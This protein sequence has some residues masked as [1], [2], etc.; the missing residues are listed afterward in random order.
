MAVSDKTS[1]GMAPP[2]R[3]RYLDGVVEYLWDAKNLRGLICLVERWA[4]V[5]P[6]S[7]TG[8]LYQIR[9]FLALRLMDRAWLQLKRLLEQDPDD[10]EALSMATEMFLDRGWPSRARKLLTDA[11]QRM[12]GA[13]ELPRLLELTEGPSRTPPTNAREIELSGAP[14]ELLELAERFLSTGSF[15]RARALLERARQADPTNARIKDLLW[16][17]DGDFDAGDISPEELASQLAPTFQDHGGFVS[18]EPP[19]AEEVT[20]TRIPVDDED[21]AEAEFPALFRRVGL[22]L[23]VMDDETG[24]VTQARHLADEDELKDPSSAPAPDSYDPADGRHEDTEIMM[25]IPTGGLDPV[26]KAEASVHKKRKQDYDL[27]STLDLQE[28]RRSLGVSAPSLSDLATQ[29]EDTEETDDVSMALEDEDADLVVVTRRERDD[30]RRPKKPNGGRTP[31]EPPSIKAP[32]RVIEKHPSSEPEPEPESVPVGPTPTPPS[33]APA[34]RRRAGG[35]DASP[36]TRPPSAPAGDDDELELPR[37]RGPGRIFLLLLLVAVPAFFAL[38]WVLPQLSFLGAGQI[39]A[40]ATKAIASDRYDRLLEIEALLEEQL[41]QDAEGGDPAL[42][43]SLARVELA[44]WAEHQPYPERL[45]EASALIER[46][47]SSEAPPPQ[48]QLAQA[49]LAAWQWRPLDARRALEAYGQQDV[50]AL[51]VRSSIAAFEG[52]AAQAAALAEQAVTAAPGHARARRLLVQRQLDADLVEQ[53][54]G[55]LAELER[56][57]PNNPRLPVLALLVEYHDNPGDLPG[58]ARDL[59]TQ[60]AQRYTPPRVEAELFE[61]VADALPGSSRSATRTWANEQA[62][63]KD[64]TDPDL[65]L[66]FARDDVAQGK[67]IEALEKLER[68]VRSRPGDLDLHMA[69][70]RTLIDLD[71]MDQANEQVALAAKHRPDHQQLGLLRAWPIIMDQLPRGD[72]ATLAQAQAHLAPIIAQHP[73]HAEALWLTGLAKLAAG[74]EGALTDLTS[75]NQHMLDVKDPSQR[76]LVSRALAS[77]VMAGHPGTPRLLAHLEENAQ[78][79]PWVHLF[80]AWY[81]IQRGGR[82]L[83]AKRLTMAVEASPEMGR[84]HYERA[85]FARDVQRDRGAARQAFSRYLR[86]EPTGRRAQEAKAAQGQ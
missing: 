61:R 1:P 48:A 81:N 28:Y 17:L 70:V 10:M 86:I 37:R 71:R 72:A 8:R 34:R 4:A 55:S 75:S 20:A 59:S 31:A 56:R 27:R 35:A 2:T 65:L 45:D 40:S 6:P 62:F 69:L 11:Q 42:L 12:P 84:A 44:L 5:E 78:A 7:K 66:Y 77:L 49:E 30:G 26:N 63:T 64:S 9:A 74:Q 32:M 33:A 36:R 38:R 25:V 60:L 76:E 52:D 22:G 46:A 18:L 13:P 53:A 43:S 79:D 47:L 21:I 85:V 82:S 29:P 80:L 39:V 57:A 51:L 54:R 16:G 50:D 68:A 19:G 23:P 67:L 83:A 3:L 15:L 24:E 58:A 41:P 73:E 14:A